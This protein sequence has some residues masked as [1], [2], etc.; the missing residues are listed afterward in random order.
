VPT[1]QET[2]RDLLLSG[3][4]RR[5]EAFLEAGDSIE[6]DLLFDLRALISN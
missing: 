3:G 2:D 1:G 5:D 6:S 4:E